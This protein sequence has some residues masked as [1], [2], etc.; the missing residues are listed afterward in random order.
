AGLLARVDSWQ[1]SVSL[2]AVMNCRVNRYYRLSR[3]FYP[4]PCPSFRATK[5]V[6]F[7]SYTAVSPPAVLALENYK[8]WRAGVEVN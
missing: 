1:E 5:R 7:L 6:N 4:R 3:F 8:F 2:S